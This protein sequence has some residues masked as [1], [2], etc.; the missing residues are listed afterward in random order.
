MS[1]ASL[2]AGALLRQGLGR[3]VV[4][5][6]P[7]VLIAATTTTSPFSTTP[8]RLFSRTAPV[9][10]KRAAKA[11]SSPNKHQLAA[12]AVEDSSSSSNS[13]K[14]HHPEPNPEN[15][16]DLA[17]VTARWAD[18]DAHFRDI[19]T[20]HTSR[21][22]FA[23]DVLGRVPIKV[24][25]PVPPDVLAQQQ[26][27]AASAAAGYG[28]KAAAAAASAVGR[29]PGAPLGSTPMMTQEFPLAQLA[30][31]VEGKGRQIVIIANEAGFVKA[32]MSA[33]QNN[34]DYNQQP[35]RGDSELELVMKVELTLPDEAARQIGETVERWRV[36]VRDAR[37]RREKTHKAWKNDKVV[38]PDALRKIDKALQMAQDRK[39]DEIKRFED[40]LLRRIRVTQL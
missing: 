36:K 33:I 20:K 5:L 7:R 1:R 8:V 27:A 24:S 39:M 34:E 28:K 2:Q 29:A 21:G 40:D 10:K 17:D 26:A 18:A 32:I 4:T 37:S 22:R 13:K 14:Q 15:P 23:P 12:S 9:L 38:T 11:P 35:Q 6:P 19:L 25:V 3:G 31:I 16:L 30:Q